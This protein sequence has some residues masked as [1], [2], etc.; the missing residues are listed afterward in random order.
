MMF[1]GVARKAYPWRRSAIALGAV[2]IFAGPPAFAA[3]TCQN[4]KGETVKCGAP[5]AMPVGWT[6]PAQERRQQ[7]PEMAVAVNLP[8]LMQTLCALGIFFALLALMPDF[9]GSQPGEWDR[10]EGELRDR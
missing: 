2:F 8:Q 5:G 10:E 6:L 3:P 9:D 4:L 7:Q 1:P